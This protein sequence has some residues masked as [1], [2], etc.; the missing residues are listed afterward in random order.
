MK[1]FSVCRKTTTFFL[2]FLIGVSGAQLKHGDPAIRVVGTDA[3]NV[4]TE[5][6]VRDDTFVT[7]V[8]RGTLLKRLDKRGDWYQVQLSD[9]RAVW[10]HGRYAEEQTARDLLEVVKAAVNVRRSSTTGSAKVGSVKRGDM[11]ALL[12]ER[13]GWYR[14]ILPDN[15]RGWLRSDM[16]VRRHLTPPE[17][18]AKT[19]KA[20]EPVLAEAKPPPPEPKPVDHYRQGKALLADRDVDGAIAAFLKAT[21]TQKDNGEAHFELAKLLKQRGQ[22][23]DALVHFRRAQRL[24]APDETKF[25]I[26][27]ILQ[28]RADSASAAAGLDVVEDPAEIDRGE[29]VLADAMVYLLPALAVGSVVFMAVLGLV[30]WRRRRGF[31]P[32][33]PVYRRRKPDAGFD[34][35]LKYAVEKRPLLRAIEEA[36][37]RRSELDQA[38]QQRFSAFEGAQISGSRLPGGASSEALLKK[39]EDLRQVIQ[40]QEERAQIYSDLIVM[41]NQKLEALDE[42]IDALKKL[43]QIDYQEGA[44]KQKK[45]TADRTA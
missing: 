21:E 40:N 9:G 30:F 26:E 33:K 45:G 8:A 19:E 31:R 34:S 41:Q 7:R 27:E 17:A 4:R 16:V 35:V 5:P 1:T 43:I 36:E 6:Q 20:P 39:V 23:D 44:K 3:V 28:A 15:K 11:L 12:Q 25:F 22:L 24:G 14:V 32:D 37:R 13:N 18:P 10:L 29:S 38:L 2:L 42:E